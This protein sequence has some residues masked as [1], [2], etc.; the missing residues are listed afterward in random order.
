MDFWKLQ[1][2]VSN[3]DYIFKLV[4]L[5]KKL[6]TLLCIF[7]PKTSKVFF[8][9]L[10]NFAWLIIF[11]IN[12]CP[13]YLYSSNNNS[14]P[15][16]ISTVLNGCGIAKVDVGIHFHSLGAFTY[17]VSTIFVDFWSSFL[18][19][20]VLLYKILKIKSGFANPGSPQVADI[21]CEH[22]LKKNARIRI[23]L[24]VLQIHVVHR[25]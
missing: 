4:K 13:K 18:L 14:V 12:H 16:P 10:C 5:I 3:F 17:Y 25:M 20:E 24:Q 23:G 15:M 8:L 2:E 11:D 21:L 7:F 1:Q 6:K 19:S 22:L 9:N